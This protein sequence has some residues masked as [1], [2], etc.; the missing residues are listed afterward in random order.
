M[1]NLLNTLLCFC[2]KVAF[3][4]IDIYVKKHQEAGKELSGKACKRD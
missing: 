2:P 3:R 4:R 1:S